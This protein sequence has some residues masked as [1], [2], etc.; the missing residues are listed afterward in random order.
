M[1]TGIFLLTVFYLIQQSYFSS[2]S[3]VFFKPIFLQYIF[4]DIMKGY[5]LFPQRSSNQVFLEKEKP[6]LF[7]LQ[8]SHAPIILKRGLF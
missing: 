8:F 3:T 5:H 1:L 6:N 4:S 2:G 7:N